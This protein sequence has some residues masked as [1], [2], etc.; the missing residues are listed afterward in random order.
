MYSVFFDT[1]IDCTRQT[2]SDFV[3]YRTLHKYFGWYLEHGSTWGW[4]AAYD[5]PM[6]LMLLPQAFLQRAFEVR[7]CGA[8]SDGYQWGPQ[9]HANYLLVFL[10]FPFTHRHLHAHEKLSLDRTEKFVESSKRCSMLSSVRPLLAADWYNEK[11]N[12]T[13]TAFLASVSSCG[14]RC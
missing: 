2:S 1:Q 11:Y 4:S 12:A 6:H 13:D 3:T 5:W 14:P 7:C 10:F 9:R 8:K